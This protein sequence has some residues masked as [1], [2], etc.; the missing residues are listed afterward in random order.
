[1]STTSGPKLGPGRSSPIASVDMNTQRDLSGLF[2]R[3]GSVF[4]RTHQHE[5]KPGSNEDIERLLVEGY[6]EA[7]ALELEQ[8]RIERRIADL[9]AAGSKRADRSP[10][11]E[12]RELGERRL[13]RQ[14][15]IDRLRS[16]LEELRD[17]AASM[18]TR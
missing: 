7:I 16:M 11:A 18:A 4:N 5:K 17:F 10:A 2:S 3:I 8:A 14:Q 1:M 9:F 12:L 13:A 15:E 6:A